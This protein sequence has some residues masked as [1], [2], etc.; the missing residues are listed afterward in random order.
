M[1]GNDSN[2]DVLQL[3]SQLT[4]TSEVTTILAKY[5][6]WDHE[7]C[8]LRLPALS[9]EGLDIHASVD[10]IKPASW[11]RNVEVARVNLESC[12]IMGQQMVGEEVP[13]M[14]EVLHGIKEADNVDILNPF[15]ADIV[16]SLLETDEHKVMKNSPINTTVTPGLSTAQSASMPDF[17]DAILKEEPPEKHNPCFEFEDNKVYK[18]CYLNQKFKEYKT[19]GSSDH[20]K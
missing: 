8:Q 19:P 14:A 20:L 3:A 16:H 7:P 10:H 2:L 1:V 17:R 11:H 6:Q 15:R 9:K 12:W 5:P 18:A 13:H 4:G